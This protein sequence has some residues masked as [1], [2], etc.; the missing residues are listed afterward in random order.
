[1]GERLALEVNHRARHLFWQLP[2]AAKRAVLV[3]VQ[4]GTLE[5]YRRMMSIEGDDPGTL[6][7][8]RKG[9]IFVHIPKTAGISIVSSLFGR[10]GAPG[11]LALGIYEAV[12]APSVFSRSV[13]VAFVRNPW[14]RL[15][16]A[17]EFLR[18]G[19]ANEEDR[20]WS[21]AHL[22]GYADFGDFVRTWLD[23][24]NIWREI[25]FVPQYSFVRLRGRCLL[26]VT[27]HFETL[28]EDYAALAVRFG[29]AP[30]LESLNRTGSRSR[31]YRAYY[32]PQTTRRVADVYREDIALFGYSFGK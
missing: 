15:V 24:R 16:S 20:R 19:G 30:K 1:V 25:H 21:S 9:C 5:R 22:Q 29:G 13:K 23:R 3:T 6:P 2:R 31:D 8:L 14:D 4:R 27:A 28:E 10:Y 12:L 11:H 18:A 26:D 17:F 32:D 7:W